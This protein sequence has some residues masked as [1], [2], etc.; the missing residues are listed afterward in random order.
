M[1]K[2]PQNFTGR[3]K[4]QNGDERGKSHE[5]GDKQQ[6][7]SNLNNRL[8][9]LVPNKMENTNLKQIMKG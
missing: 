1:K 3:A 8:R 5:V 4:Q 7:L 9:F 2:N 6:E